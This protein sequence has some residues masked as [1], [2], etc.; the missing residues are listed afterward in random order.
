MRIVSLA[1]FC[2]FC[3]FSAQA[4]ER[5]DA[6]M[7]KKYQQVKTIKA[8][9]EQ[10]LTHKESGSVEQRHG[11]LYFQKPL[12][13]R[14]ETLKPQ[15][16]LLIINDKEIWN[17][18]ADEEIAYRYTPQLV[19]D[20]RSLIQVITGQARLDQDFSVKPLGKDGEWEKLQLYPKE[21]TPELVEATLWV[22]PSTKLIRRAVIT[23]FYGNTNDI[24]FT[25]L[26]TN[27]NLPKDSFQFQAP[28]GVEVEDRMD[29]DI[30]E[31][32]LFK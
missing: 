30:Q 3:A 21:P 22:E 6:E 19:Q 12:L 24:T 26:N 8:T 14:W 16:E 1:L 20:S 28:K 9:F 4:A 25:E 27:L 23:D 18:L 15:K 10:K 5:I 11:S 31:K 29:K 2:L 32:P 7:Q 13:I 17:Y